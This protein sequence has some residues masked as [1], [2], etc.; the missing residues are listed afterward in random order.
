MK[1]A[2][3]CIHWKLSREFQFLFVQLQQE[4]SLHETTHCTK[5]DGAWQTIHDIKTCHVGEKHGECFTKYQTRKRL[6]SEHEVW[7]LRRYIPCNDRLYVNERTPRP[8]VHTES[9]KLCSL[10][11]SAR[12]TG[13]LWEVQPIWPSAD[14]TKTSASRKVHTNGLPIWWLPLMRRWSL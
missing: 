9:A 7:Y 13:R 6:I 1:F 5:Q 12:F 2:T 10:N 4:H 11:L 14:P 3:R 8:M